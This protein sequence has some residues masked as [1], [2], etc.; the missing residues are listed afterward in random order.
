MRTVGIYQLVGEHN[1]AASFVS[2]Y[3]HGKIATNAVAESACL[4]MTASYVPN[5][6]GAAM[7]VDD[8]VKPAEERHQC[9]SSFLEGAQ[10]GFFHID[11]RVA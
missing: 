11:T 2:I 7:P 9:H 6:D 4:H 8:I 1:G 10:P 5:V 3:V